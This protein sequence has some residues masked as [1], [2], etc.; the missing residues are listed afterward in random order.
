MEN[1]RL[2]YFDS[3]R[4]L[5]MYMVVYC[6]I[7]NFIFHNTESITFNWFSNIMLPLFF[8]ISG[9][10]SWKVKID[11]GYKF[12]INKITDL[13][14]PAIVCM[15]IYI[16]T[17]NMNFI[18][19]IFDNYK[20]G[21]WFTFV[22]AEMFIFMYVINKLL[23]NKST[24]YKTTVLIVGILIF[25]IIV[26]VNQN[27]LFTNNN[28]SQAFSLLLFIQYIQYFMFGSVLKINFDNI[29]MAFERYKMIIPILI[30]IYVI[31][32]R[33]DG[34]YYSSFRSYI[35]IILFFYLFFYYKNKV[36]NF[37]PT[38]ILYVLGQSTKQIYFIH[39]F[40]LFGLM[41]NFPIGYFSECIAT[42]ILELIIVGLLSL[43]ICF[44]CVY[45]AKTIK[46]SP[47]LDKMLFGFKLCK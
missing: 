23:Y 3:L 4:G 18:D 43:I 11:K 27:I 21:Y 17:F 45:I 15:M 22:L 12:I 14:V 40:L 9:F 19:S 20:G 10:F 38:K 41:Y 37:L 34:Y 35:N 31:L 28:L 36:I 47:Y 24:I 42:P 8:L 16:Y 44:G 1:I 13:V 6:H 29:I 46:I 2:E 5:S 39:Y 25:N 32:L 33:F 30:L 26:K 7:N